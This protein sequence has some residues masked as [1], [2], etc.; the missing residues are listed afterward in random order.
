[1]TRAVLGSTNSAPA[2]DGKRLTVRKLGELLQGL[3]D[4]RVIA[5]HRDRSVSGV[6]DDSR[7][8]QPD[9][10]FVAVRGTA[11]DGRQYVAQALQRG[12]TVLI[13][14]ELPEHADAVVINVPDA[15][16]V[17]GRLA[18][19][20]HGLDTRPA[21]EMKLLAVTGTNGKTTTA[22]M[23]RAIIQA[24]GHKCGL[25]GTVRYDLCGR[26]VAARMTT[27]GALEL[28]SCLRECADAGAT[29]GVL[30]VSSHALDQQRTAGLRFSAAAFTNLSGDH[31]DYH[32]TFEKYRATKA[33]L[34]A[35]LDQS[36]VAVLNRDDA[37]SEQMVRG[38]R[39]RVVWYSI[40]E[41]ADI[42]GSISQDTIGGTY[43]RM[44]IDGRNLVLENAVVGRHNVYNALAAAGLARALGMPLE[45]IE[46]GLAAVRNIPGRLQRVPC[47]SGA[48]VF[49]DY[50]H[51]DDALRN[52]LSVLR[53]LARRR[54]IVVF[55]C[56]GDRDRAKRP[57][58]AQAVAE[59]ADVIIVTSD[60]PRTEDP[61][62]IIA[63][64][65]TGFETDVRRR[66]IVEPAR[67]TAI[68]ASLA[69][70]EAGDV[71]LIAGKGHEDYQIIGDRRVHFDDVEAAIQAAAELSGKSSGE[72]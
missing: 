19:R 29:I 10:I 18:V 39:A 64:I 59:H 7:R 2:A 24:A 5:S 49:V 45:A 12:A 66:V 40:E 32:G 41:D 51:T 70:A 26:S 60:N 23:T 14:E 27:P 33:R 57:R 72:S 63:D 71:V 44:R 55:G 36:A 69:A 8:V 50:A 35:D 61:Q 52:V 34:F 4:E 16:A 28:A 20:W 46:A 11:V 13:G 43:Y 22:I 48:D 30:E 67:A 38:S 25:L 31:L 9:G 3:V 68:R 47:V 58:M 21:S 15:R 6:F 56:G 37:A 1:M 17:L 62:R 65:L 42:T 53:P 54:L